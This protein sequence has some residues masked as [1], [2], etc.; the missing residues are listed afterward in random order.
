MRFDSAAAVM[1]YV[2]QL[3]ARGR[4]RVEPNPQV[5]A[6]V[7]D[8]DLR[9]IAQGWHERYGGPHA[10]VVALEAA[11]RSAQG[12]TL[13]VSLEPC[14]HFGKTPPCTNAIL[15]AGIRRVIV[16]MQ[17]PFPAVDGGGIHTL[18][19]AGVEVE[20]G[21]LEEPARALNAPFLRLIQQH[22][23]WVHGKWAM[24]LDGQIAAWNGQSQWITGTAARERSHQL[25]GQMDA[26]LV[27][28]G[29]VLADDP[30]LTARPPGTRCPTR[31]VLDSNARTPLKSQLVAS[32]AQA[33]VL[34][35]AGCQAPDA[36][37]DGLR[38]AGAEVWR[39]EQPKPGLGEV[40][41]ELGRRSMTHVLIEGGRTVL[42]AAL[43]ADLV[44]E[45]HVYVAPRLVGGGTMSPIHGT[46]AASI[47]TGLLLQMDPV[48]VLGHDLYWHG[49]VM[50]RR[51]E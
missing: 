29:T 23:P 26:I 38:Q 15:A 27:G 18:R 42:G 28:I 41:A 44:D 45:V 8:D 5:G 50:P 30:L 16:A 33:P 21:L 10:E 34:I 40:L 6:V 48:E 12:Q 2:L 49:T 31:I 14:C 22:R 20:M 51:P 35:C 39:S 4:G 36:Q 43:A 46:G 25:R 7:V 3:A 9:L 19:Q 37:V 11:G 47:A 24:T 13:F 17:D 32:I 1:T